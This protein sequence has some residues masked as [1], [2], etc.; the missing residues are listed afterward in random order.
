MSLPVPGWASELRAEGW[1]NICEVLG[2][3]P[4]RLT[5]VD[6][7]LG[8]VNSHTLILGKDSAPSR[9]FRKLAALGDPDPYRHDPKLP[10]NRTISLVLKELGIDAPL[11]GS[12]AETC[13]LY[14]ANAYWLLRDDDRFS[15]RLPNQAEALAASAR[16]LEHILQ[17]LP[18]LKRVIAMGK[19]SFE[20]ISGFRNQ[21]ADWRAHLASGRPVELDDFKL[22]ASVHMGHFGIGNRLPGASRADCLK[23]VRDDWRRALET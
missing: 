12:R 5:A 21:P 8:D 7:F 11:D 3:C 2:A 10:T 19:D 16:I 13:G 20:A 18:K 14:Y 17:S 9:V 4:P 23:A 22:H 6:A 15:G 1:A